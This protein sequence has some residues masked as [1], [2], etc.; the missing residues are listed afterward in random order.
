M[1]S[2]IERYADRILGVL[3]C[4]DRVV[5]TGTLPDI[6]H[7]RAMARH[8]TAQH[9][10]IFDYTQWAQPLREEIRSH[11]EALAAE[12]DLEIEFIRRN[13]F[14][15]E[16]RVKKILAQ[17]GDH[18]GLVHIFS[19]M[20]RCAAYQP[21]HDKTT[22]K[23]FLK[24]TQSKCLHYYFYF[25]DEEL[26]LCYLR[27][28][29]WAPFR[30]QFYCNGHNIL[31]RALDRNAI[32]Y[33]LVDNAFVA[34][35]DFERAQHLADAL[36]VPGL[37][38]RLDQLAQRFCPA[39]GRFPGGVH[40]S[41][42]QCEYATDVVFRRREDL[43]PAYQA[44]V[45]R[46]VHTVQAEQV[47][48]FLGRKLH[49]AYQGEVGNDFHTRIQGTRIRHHMGQ[50]SI[51]MYDKHGRVLRIETTA[52]DVS[53]FKHHRRV[54]HRD[55]TWEMKLAP[56]KK[57]IYSLSVLRQLL[58]A[59][60]RRYLDF[61]ASLDDPRRGTHNLAKLSQ[62][63][64]KNGRTFRGF[65]LFHAEDLSLFHALLR[66]EFYISGLTCRRLRAVLG[67]KTGPQMSRLLRRL[68]VHGLIRKVGRTYKYYLTARGQKAILAA[69]HLRETLIIPS[70]A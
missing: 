32:G 55:G 56:V 36:P 22:H 15:K 7:S 34:I 67:D 60:N 70:L 43:H 61:L 3:S 31:A 28:P 46:A 44:W 63:V 59:A 21:W 26:G 69:L 19:A 50:V 49:G 66:G 54:E 39:V 65:N 4:Y 41:L 9:I 10:R 42:M 33:T 23:T 29:T 48:T 17:R 57:T 25:I 12:N 13:N 5:I 47:A 6:C 64:R 1:A 30:L 37:H 38:R 24:P 51:K 20:E 62:T 35:A 14:R 27:V 18:P 68:R 11:A 45:R 58:G 16:D 2:V 52:S 53:F 8:L 40:W